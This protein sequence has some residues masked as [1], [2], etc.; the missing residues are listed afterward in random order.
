MLSVAAPPHDG[1]TATGRTIMRRLTPDERIAAMQKLK[2]EALR[3]SD[4]E[5]LWVAKLMQAALAADSAQR[6]R[7]PTRSLRS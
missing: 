1:N 7:S 4:A 3:R 5:S 2:D 6:R